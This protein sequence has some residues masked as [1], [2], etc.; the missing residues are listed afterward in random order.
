MTMAKKVAVIGAGASGLCAIKCCLDEGLQPTC[1]ERS[2]DFGGLWR[3]KETPDLNTA[4]IYK[5]LIINTSKEMSCFSDFPV[6][7]DYAIYM[8]HSK[9][10]QYF[11]MYAKHFGL[12]KYI[13][14]ETNVCS[15]KKRPD[16]LTTGQWDVTIKNKRGEQKTDIF[17]AVLVCT[18]HHCD[19]YLPLHMFPGIEKF[20]GPYFHSRDY[21]SPLDFEGKRVT[22]IGLGSSGGDLSVEI[23]R[24]ASQVFLS[25]RRGAWVIN[26]V[27]DN[28]YP[29][30]MSS[31]SRFSNTINHLLPHSLLCSLLERKLNKR[32]NHKNYGLQ[33]KHRILSQQIT[34]NDELPNRIISGTILIKP[35]VKEFT[36]TAVVFEDGTVEENIDAAI[37]ATGYT[38]S[39]P[40]LEASIIDVRSNNTNLYKYVFP[41]HLEQPT[42][43]VIGLVQPVG[44][45]MPVSEMQC[46]WAAR[47]FKGLVKLPSVSSMMEDI[48]KK[49]DNLSRRYVCTQRHTLQVDYINYMDEIAEAFGAKPKMLELFYRNPRLAWKVFFDSCTP[50]QYRLTGPGKWSGAEKAVMTQWD[51]VFKATMTRCVEVEKQQKTFP[52][53]L[54]LIFMVL[55]IAFFVF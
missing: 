26:R 53:L 14:L 50:Y 7:D 42:L 6:P 13:Q 5:S 38:F 11:R 10:M 30:D 54:M 46:R 21:K 43:A 18:G 2:S 31:T 32:F 37:F 29:L 3:F 4:S 27:S 1:F 48:A 52:V 41:P 25:T 44:A 51:R 17:D 23:S 55:M 12:Q 40:F 45:I 19:P 39:Y 16:F 28:G 35:N 22:V 9:I 36:E 15:V 24:T 34:V 20:K 49:Q 33:P 8:H 47:V